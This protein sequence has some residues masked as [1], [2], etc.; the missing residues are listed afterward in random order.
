MTLQEK[1]NFL[2]YIKAHSNESYL[3]ARIMIEYNLRVN[4]VACLKIKHLEFLLIENSDRIIF[5]DPK[6]KIDK[7]NTID[8]ILKEEIIEFLGNIQWDEEE[9]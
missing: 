3:I 7:Q 6:F 5:P 2:F 9:E 8:Q 4:S 1:T